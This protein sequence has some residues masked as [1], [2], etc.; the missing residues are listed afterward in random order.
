MHTQFLFYC[1]TH[2]VRCFFFHRVFPPPP[3]LSC[4]YVFFAWAMFWRR[5]IQSPRRGKQR[6]R[7]PW[8]ITPTGRARGGPKIEFRSPFVWIC[9]RKYVIRWGGGVG[10]FARLLDRVVYEPA[11]RFVFSARPRHCRVRRPVRNGFRMRNPTSFPG[12]FIATGRRG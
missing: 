2:V 6:E 12:H 11:R 4:A 1:Q 7:G 5:S 8:R 9:G 10:W 3:V